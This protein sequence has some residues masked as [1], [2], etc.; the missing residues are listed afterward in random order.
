ME[1]LLTTYRQGRGVSA[2][3]LGAGQQPRPPAA[4][5]AGQQRHAPAAGGGGP[6][7]GRPQQRTRGPRHATRV[8]GR[9]QVHVHPAQRPGGALLH[10]AGH[11]DTGQRVQHQVRGKQQFVENIFLK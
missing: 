1:V 11:A 3:V 2:A 4:L 8:P 6:G 5:P 7:G 9:A 10:G